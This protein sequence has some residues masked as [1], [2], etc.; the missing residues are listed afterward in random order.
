[1]V[2]PS[3][4]YN[5]DGWVGIRRYLLE[6]ASIECF[7]GF[8]NRQEMPDTLAF[9]EYRSPRH[10]EIVCKMY[11]G[12]PT[13]GA[14]GP[15]SWGAGLINWRAH[16][17]IFNSAEDK[18]LFTEARTG[19][20]WS[21]ALVLGFEPGDIG[22][23]IDRM[24]EK[25]FWPVF[26]GK[27]IDQFL[28]GVKPVRWWLSVEQAKRKYGRE[29]R[30]EPTLVFRETASNTNERTCIAA[31]LPGKCAGSH[32]LTGVLLRD[33]DPLAA[34]TVLNSFCFDYALR[35]RTAGTNVSFTYILPVAV[36]SAEVSRRLPRVDVRYSW[37]AGI[38]H[39]SED[40]SL[41]PALWAANRAVAEAYGLNVADLSHVLASFPGF[42]RKRPEFCAFLQA[43]L[44][45][46]AAGPH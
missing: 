33:V 19:R 35:L 22:E 24:R 6:A 13:L 42:A 31:V 1:L 27:H 12:R 18:D 17:V 9:L 8:E 14:E 25:G 36:P 21:P 7:Y 38:E 15:G 40:R 44:A 11:A 46:W 26:E 30:A 28:V 41:W 20:L 3:V 16:E 5:G 2:A 29:P 45:E 10:Q 23:A 32:K 43:R 34:L 37:D 4:F 39:I